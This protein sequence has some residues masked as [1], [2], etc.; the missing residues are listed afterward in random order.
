MRAGGRGEPRPCLPVLPGAGGAG[1]KLP[2]RRGGVWV[3]R[4]KAGQSLPLWTLQL[5]ELATGAGGRHERQE[6]ELHLRG[7]RRVRAAVR[8]LCVV[9][10]CPRPQAQPQLSQYAPAPALPV[11]ASP[12]SA[13]MPQAQ[14]SSLCP[15]PAL[16]AQAVPCAPA[17]FPR[18]LSLPGPALPAP[19]SS[20]PEGIRA[21]MGTGC[22]RH[23]AGSRVAQARGGTATPHGPP[24]TAGTQGRCLGAKHPSLDAWAPGS[25]LPCSWLVG[26][27]WTSPLP[28][29][30]PQFPPPH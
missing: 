13:S 3:R 30:M 22:L 7:L 15:S 24:L 19:S 2:R 14:P 26:Y 23:G 16:Q 5:Q 29:F 11:Q 28:R 9:Q 4:G 8:G 21:R 10:L 18:A 6:A 27:L 1:R 25:H 17:P 12:S 20:A